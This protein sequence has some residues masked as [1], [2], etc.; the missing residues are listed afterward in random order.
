MIRKILVAVDGSPIAAEVLVTG[1]EIAERFDAS[2][3]LLRVIQ[4]PPEF[5]AAAHLSEGD[6]LPEMMRV[7]AIQML[8]ALAA[9]HPRAQV[10]PVSIRSGQPWREICAAAEELDADLVV[11]GSHGYGGW[12]RLLGTTAARVVDHASRNVFVVRSRPR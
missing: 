8:S 10:S 1:V 9:L 12:D 7:E 2:M 5:P 6:P 11:L 4:I 3:V